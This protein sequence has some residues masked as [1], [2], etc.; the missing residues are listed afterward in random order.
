MS[1]NSIWETSNDGS[2]L[3]VL[4]S[5]RTGASDPLQG[6]WTP[7]GKYYLYQAT[8]GSR[9]DIWAVRESGDAFHRVSREPVQ[10]TAGPLSFFSPQPSVDGKRIFAI[11]VQLRAELV[12]HD[13]KSAQFVP[14][15]GGISATW[16]SFSR[17]GQWITY[18]SYPEGE[19]WRSRADGTEKLQLTH[20]SL[21]AGSSDF[22]PDG[23]Q[24]LFTA[25]TSGGR[26][27]A[28]LI[29]V[30]GG[31]PRD[32]GVEAG[33]IDW[34]GQGNSMTF[35]EGP[36]DRARILLFDLKTSQTTEIPDSGGLFMSRCSNDGRYI[37]AA[38]RDGKKLKLYDFNTRTWSDLVTRDIGFLQWS[39]DNRYIYF[40]SGFSEELAVYRVRIA[41]RKLEKIA[42]LQNFRRVVE[43]WV[44]W[45]GLTPDGDPLFMRDVGNQEVYA[46]DFEEP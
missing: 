32:I 34:C 46:L 21:Q 43:P 25:V 45:M 31:T 42:D 7:D 16:V 9:S 29:S 44:S 23:K 26:Q 41:D 8:R 15:L 6:N 2:G 22:S 27:R 10:L 35:T 33:R 28:N 11:G 18:V 5:G 4:L 38:S 20:A 39:A 13:A 19:L 17:D 30:D 3:R 24:I 14:Y 12:R 37:A 1:H 40:D 36:S